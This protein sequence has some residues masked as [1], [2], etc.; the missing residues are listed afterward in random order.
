[1]NK[2]ME[3]WKKPWPE[4]NYE[5]SNYGNVRRELGKVVNNTMGGFRKVGGKNLSQKTKKNGYKEVSIYLT[6]SVGKM[7]YVHRLVAMAFIGELPDECE[8]NHKDGNKANN[9]LQNLEIVTPSENRLHAYHGLKKGI[10][11]YKGSNHGMSKLNEEKVLK[12]RE[13]YDGGKMPSELCI[14]F[15]VPYSTMCKICYR[16]TWKHI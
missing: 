10:G 11:V 14:E 5:V 1:M 3:I 6:P 7:F 16:Q 2:F 15:K 4:S 13:L 9:N 12:I 8:V